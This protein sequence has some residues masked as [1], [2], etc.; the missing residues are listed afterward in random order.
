MLFD[1]GADSLSSFLI[2]TAML[3]LL[4]IKSGTLKTFVMFTFVM[5]ICFAAMWSQYCVGFFR[6][7]RINPID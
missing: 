6:L 3:E 2:T 7:G 4:E 1:H 5:L